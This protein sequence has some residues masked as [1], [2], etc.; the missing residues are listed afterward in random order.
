M[1]KEKPDLPLL[2][3]RGAPNLFLEGR[4]LPSKLCLSI[5]IGSSFVFLSPGL[6]GR[7]E[8]MQWH[9]VSGS[10]RGIKSI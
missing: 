8:G 6:Y 1:A 4:I 7:G 10:L 2:A 3:L 9:T 5:P